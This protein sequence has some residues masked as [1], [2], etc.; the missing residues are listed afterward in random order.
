MIVLGLAKQVSI[1]MLSCIQ[2]VTMK[3]KVTAEPEFSS[4]SSTFVFHHFHLVFLVS[5]SLFLLKWHVK[6]EQ[7]KPDDLTG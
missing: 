3:N 7:E 1:Q 2:Q 5:S 6:Q 4:V